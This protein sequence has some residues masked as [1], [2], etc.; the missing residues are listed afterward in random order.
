MMGARPTACGYCGA[1]L[2]R[3]ETGRPRVFCSDMHRKMFARVADAELPPAPDR[4]PDATFEELHGALLDVRQ[5]SCRLAYQLQLDG[6]AV[7]HARAAAVALELDRLVTR[8][9]GRKP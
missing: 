3:A 5:S 2:V 8:H 4:R 9:F 7:G 1:E 6:D